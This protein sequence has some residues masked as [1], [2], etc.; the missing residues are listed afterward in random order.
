MEDL[1]FTSLSS[2]FVKNYL[3]P[4]IELDL[5]RIEK[6]ESPKAPNQRYIWING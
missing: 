5:I 4:A 6:P 2:M 1:V 3:K